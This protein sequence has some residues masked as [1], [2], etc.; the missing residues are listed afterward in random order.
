[1]LFFRA[2]HSSASRSAPRTS[3]WKDYIDGTIVVH[4]IPTTH[5]R[6]LDAEFRALIGRALTE[7]AS[8]PR[9]DRPSFISQRS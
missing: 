7:S 8:A 4:D 1:V 6:M 9:A 3:A 5:L 2:A